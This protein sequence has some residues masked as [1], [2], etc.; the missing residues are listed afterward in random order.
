MLS[1]DEVNRYISIDSERI[2]CFQ[3][4]VRWWWLRSPGIKNHASFVSNDGFVNVHG[5]RVD[6]S[7]SG[8]RPVL[9]L[10][11][12]M[13]PEIIDVAQLNTMQ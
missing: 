5:H 4:L 6:Y 8:V 12:D 9:Y 13:A 10:K 1:I 7:Y 11:T 2:A 3:G